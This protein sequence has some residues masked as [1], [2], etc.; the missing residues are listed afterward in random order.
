MSASRENQWQLTQNESPA[1]SVPG[2]LGP[3]WRDIV[4]LL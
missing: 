2:F 1:F 3:E 4:S